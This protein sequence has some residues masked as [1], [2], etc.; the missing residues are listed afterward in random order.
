MHYLVRLS[1]DGVITAC[2]HGLPIH[3]MS[4][5]RW[6]EVDCKSCLDNRGIEAEVDRRMAEFRRENNLDENLNP[7]PALQFGG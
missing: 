1:N 7:L 5:Y 2:S 4:G 3:E 6:G